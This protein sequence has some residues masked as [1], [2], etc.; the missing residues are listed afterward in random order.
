MGRRLNGV[1]AAICDV[2]IYATEGEALLKTLT[3]RPS[4]SVRPRGRANAL[5]EGCDSAGHRLPRL[6]G[7]A[8]PRRP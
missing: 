4:L 1:C 3:V 5:A 2:W 7:E 8:R 6:L